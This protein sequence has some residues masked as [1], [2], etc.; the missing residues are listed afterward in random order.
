[1]FAMASAG[2]TRSALTG[3]ATPHSPAR[4]TFVLSSVLT[5]PPEPPLKIT[6]IANR[7]VPFSR[8]NITTANS[9]WH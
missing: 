8:L 7:Q 6:W 4:G 2:K 3:P 1:M 5:G 9:N